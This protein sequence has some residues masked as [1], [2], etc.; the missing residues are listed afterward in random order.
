[1]AGLPFMIGDGGPGTT[2]S[3]DGLLQAELAQPTLGTSRLS[4]ADAN[5]VAPVDRLAYSYRFLHND[6]SASF[7][8][9]SEAMDLDRHTIAWER[10]FWDRGASIELRLPLEN[11]LNSRFAS[12]FDPSG[13][14]IE[15]IVGGTSARQTELGNIAAIF[16]YLLWEND[17]SAVS[18][19]LGVSL[20]TA[21]DVEH[22]TAING[23]TPFPNNPGLS[24]DTSA[25]F[26]TVFNNET[27]NL[28]P[29]LAWGIRPAERWFHQGFFQV[30]VAANPSKVLF[31]GGGQTLF[32]ENGVPIGLYEYFTLLPVPEKYSQQTLMRLNLAGG[33]ILVEAPQSRGLRQLVLHGEL[34]WTSTLNDAH[35]AD[36]PLFV[37]FAGGS[38]PLPTID[39]GG[40]RDHMNLL[41]AVLGASADVAGWTIVNGVVVPV[42]DSPDRTFDF[43][44]NIQV[45]RPY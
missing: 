18:A 5:T 9:F 12:R 33:R 20:P 30:D 15:P 40:A 44:Y 8:G 26:L 21:R 29:F 13:A 34:H 10:T 23:E 38:I 35:R 28:N 17:Y 24:G 32:L 45:Q 2:V 4:V 7:Y 42:R 1:M 37:N 36:L 39:V 43:Q 25:G 27:V 19:G 22:I 16:K 6:S 41:N 14:G 31:Q 3:F 11:R